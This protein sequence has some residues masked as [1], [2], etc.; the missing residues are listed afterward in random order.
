MRETTREHTILPA[1]IAEEDGTLVLGT[2]LTDE[3]EA[4]QLCRMQDTA[5]QWHT[6]YEKLGTAHITYQSY[7]VRLSPEGTPSP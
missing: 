4:Y 7:E 1:I 2:I 3:P 5:G 6:V